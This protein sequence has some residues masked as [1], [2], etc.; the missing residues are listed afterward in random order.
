MNSTELEHGIRTFFDLRR[1]C[2]ASLILAFLLL[3]SNAVVMDSKR[4][5]KMFDVSKV[6]S[7]PGEGGDV[8]KPGG[9]REE[10]WRPA[11]GGNGL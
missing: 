5:C 7:S 6:G 1:C 11:A 3:V 4:D 2:L 8:G 9:H 10:A